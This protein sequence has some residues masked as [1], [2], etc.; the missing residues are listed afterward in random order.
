VMLRA[1]P[2]AIGELH[3]TDAEARGIADGDAIR[4]HNDIGSVRCVASVTDKVPEGTVAVPFGRWASDP[5]SGGANSLTSDRLG[6]LANGPT[7]C[8][9]LVEVEPVGERQ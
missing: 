3:P 7:F 1:E 8:D 2:Q 5:E 9:N 6:D 4:I